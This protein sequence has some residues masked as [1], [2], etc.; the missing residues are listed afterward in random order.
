MILTLIFIFCFGI[1]LVMP[2]SC[3]Y[4]SAGPCKEEPLCCKSGY[5]TTHYCGPCR[6]CAKAEGD[7]CGGDYNLGGSCAHGL[8]CKEQKKKTDKGW[9]TLYGGTGTCEKDEESKDLPRW[10]WKAPKC[11]TVPGK[12]TCRCALE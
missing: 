7:V 1:N 5:F 4:W 10:L 11:S 6:V 12:K 8:E 2:F 9:I 3:R